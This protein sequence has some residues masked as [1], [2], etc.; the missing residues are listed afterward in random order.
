MRY[1]VTYEEFHIVPKPDH[2]SLPKQKRIA[3]MATSTVQQNPH[4]I[5]YEQLSVAVH[6]HVELSEKLTDRG[7]IE[8][9]QKFTRLLRAQVQVAYRAARRVQ[10]PLP[11]RWSTAPQTPE[12]WN[13]EPYMALFKGLD[14][15]D[16]WCRYT[17][18]ERP[19]FSI[20]AAPYKADAIAHYREQTLARLYWVL[21]RSD[22]HEPLF[23]SGLGR[24]RYCIGDWPTNQYKLRSRLPYILIW[25]TLGDMDIPLSAEWDSIFFGIGGVSFLERSTTRY[26]KKLGVEHGFMKEDSMTRVA[27]FTQPTTASDMCSICRE[28]YANDDAN[29]EPAVKTVCGHLV[30]RDCLQQWTDTFLATH[31]RDGV[32]CPQCRAALTIGQFSVVDQPIVW[33]LVNWFRND[34]ELDEEVDKFL[35]DAREEDLQRCYQPQVGVM[36]TKL[37]ERYHK[38]VELLG[39]IGIAPLL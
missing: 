16:R 13:A 22:M 28:A 3:T 17:L 31:D 39:K 32:T 10:K 6:R 8:I 19:F 27:E 2:N 33:D 24:D 14:G 38:G 34:R 7:N 36:L 15:V 23:P 9:T 21:E 1:S 35:E 26:I 25:L 37:H 29:H 5:K 12:P 20:P 30:G 18:A 11:R 4:Q